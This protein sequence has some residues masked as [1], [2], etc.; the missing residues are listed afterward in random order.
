MRPAQVARRGAEY[1]ERH[2][3]DAPEATAVALMASVLNV[4]PSDVYRWRDALTADQARAFGRSLCRR[5]A[6]TPTQHL[7]GEQG[8][9]HLVLS[10][11]PGVFVPR[12]ETEVLVDAALDLLDPTGEPVAVDVGTGSGAV[13]LS[14]ARERPGCRVWAT[15]LSPA[16]VALA[17]DEADRLGLPVAIEHGDLLE[18]LP[19]TLHGAIDLVVANLPYL[20]EEDRTSLPAEVLAEPPLALFGGATIYRRLAAQACGWLRSGGAVAVE[21]GATMGEEIAEIVRDAGFRG[22]RVLPDLAGRDRVVTG[23]R[24]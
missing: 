4:A 19:R 2:G 18:P 8:F 24:P 6:G 14:I 22:V 15:D 11:R 16:A 13:A 10:V 23:R 3:I 21:I 9:R 20:A 5:C 17:R 7:T 12:P 1:L